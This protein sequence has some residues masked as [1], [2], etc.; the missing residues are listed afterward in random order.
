MPKPRRGTQITTRRPKKE[1]TK[2]PIDGYFTRSAGKMAE[3]FPTTPE[4][5]GTNLPLP[6]SPESVSDIDIDKLVEEIEEAGETTP[7][8]KKKKKANQKMSLESKVDMLIKN[9]G[10][11]DIKMNILNTTLSAKVVNLEKNIEKKI[12]DWK[13]KYEKRLKT[14]E[15]YVQ[16]TNEINAKAVANTEAITAMQDRIVKLEESLVKATTSIDKLT[17]ELKNTKECSYK[18]VNKNA[19]L[20]KT[21][22]RKLREKNVRIQ[23]V[24]VRENEQPEAAVL[25]TLNPVF[26]GLKQT[27]I[28]SAVKVFKKGFTGI[29]DE[30]A[31]APVRQGDGEEDVDN[32][33]VTP[34][35]QAQPVLLVEFKTREIRDMIYFDGRKNKTKFL[36]PIIIREDMIKADYQ[37]WV[38]AKPQMEAAWRPPRS[39]K[40]RFQHGR[41][42]INGQRV[43]IDG[44]EQLERLSFDS[45]FD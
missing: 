30:G 43:A 38:L 40:V 42:T 12:T 23:N 16:S 11:L 29:Q 41:L 32:D 44:I 31:P 39:A 15:T 5:D 8:G 25:R 33:N 37:A 35:R 13:T 10:K 14:V 19:F 2:N 9:I 7:Q 21:L 22:Q 3:A 34:A 17:E 24:E 18:A 45:K 6:E 26:P 1:P 27:D 28:L 4:K 20:I 36:P